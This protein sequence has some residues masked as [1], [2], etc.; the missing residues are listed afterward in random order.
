MEEIN[1]DK[2]YN[3]IKSIKSAG[4]L[5]SLL[6]II[7]Q[8]L[9][10]AVGARYCSLFIKNPISGEL[11]LK[12]HNHQDIGDDPF[13]HVSDNDRSTMNLAI[14]RGSSLLIKDI[15]Q[16]IG[17]HNKD[18]YSTKSFMCLLIKDDNNIE[19]VLNLADKSPDG[20]TRQ[21]ML[22]STIISEI[23]GSYLKRF[24]IANA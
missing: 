14:S 1:L 15:E 11:E 10:A 19:G 24:G 5:E 23:I 17:Y 4:S 6:G 3:L 16:E 7:T 12:A 18:K 20:F 9:P 22:F 13:I 21:D 8:E 2:I